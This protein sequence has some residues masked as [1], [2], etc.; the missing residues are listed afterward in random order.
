M[1]EVAAHGALFLFGGQT[2]ATLIAAAGSIVEET[3]M[4]CEKLHNRGI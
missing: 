3:V 4:V 2:L 1:A